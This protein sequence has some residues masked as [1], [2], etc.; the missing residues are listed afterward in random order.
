AEPQQ[1][2][3]GECRFI[4]PAVDSVTGSRQ[5]CIC[6]G[7][8]HNRRPVGSEC[9]CGHPAWV[10][11][12][13]P[14]AVVTYEEHAALVEEVRRLKQD[15]HTKVQRLQQ[16][17]AKVQQ[18]LFVSRAQTAERERLLKMIEARMYQN[19]KALKLEIDDKMDGMIDQQHALQRKLI[20][21][22]DTTMEHEI[23]FEGLE[24][25]KE[26]PV[27]SLSPA[28]ESA[29]DTLMDA[30]VEH[31]SV[32]VEKPDFRPRQPWEMNVIVVPRRTQHYAFDFGS[33]G[34]KRSQSRHL[35]LTL[36][37]PGPDSRHFVNTIEMALR[38]VLKGRPWMPLQAFRPPDDQLARM[39]LHQLPVEHVVSDQWNYSFLDHYCIAHDKMLGDLLYITLQT[40]ELSWDEIKCLPAAADVDE[41]CWAHDDE[42][43]GPPPK[44]FERMDAELMYDYLEPP[45]YSSR[46]SQMEMERLQTPLGVLAASAAHLPPLTKQTTAQSLRSLESQKSVE[47]EEGS[48]N[49][50]R[51]KIRK[52]RAKHSEPAM[53]GGG[54]SS[55]A[56]QPQYYS[57]R[58]K[59]KMPVRE[60]QKQPVQFKLPSMPNMPNILHRHDTR[61]KD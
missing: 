35:H 30:D 16:E 60:K 56:K 28:Q 6:Q 5:R 21:V 59:R 33:N 7:F 53:N 12:Q 34:Y 1:L 39:A 4:Q 20:D 13:Q 3:R 43:D 51:A 11:V 32:E 29:V 46:R 31:P 14:M 40:E 49:E 58:S 61:G 38:D 54:S 57:G 25:D 42:L 41:S 22:E 47:M 15:Q 17:L 9:E 2:P 18:E 19:M 36:E 8:S 45:P 26:Q 52:L 23:K 44:N 55:S 48:D 10:H 27:R 37:F 50:H 24:A